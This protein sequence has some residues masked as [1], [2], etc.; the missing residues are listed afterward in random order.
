MAHTFDHFN[1]STRWAVLL[2]A[3]RYCAVNHITEG[4]YLEFGS[5]GA[6]TFRMAYDAFHY[7]FQWK[8][9]AFDSFD[10][11]PEI[12]GVDVQADVWK[13]GMYRISEED[14]IHTCLR[15]GLP[16]DIFST[17]KGYYEEMLT[18][19]LRDGLLPQKAAV[20][21]IDCDLYASAACILDWVKELLQVGT[22]LIFD[23][24]YCC[25]YGDPLRGERAAFQEF[26]EREPG[27]RFEPFV[28]TH[29]VQAF[30]YLGLRDTYAH[31]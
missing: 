31:T 4:Y 7:L 15:H 26:L 10:G 22:V 19:E 21:Y 14:F 24:W 5:Y 8:Y 25:Y 20:I 17:I 13:K 16:R 9:L 3:A 12:K 1:W 11:L 30:V 18:P 28:R 23:D 6:H 29:E 27:L 2:S